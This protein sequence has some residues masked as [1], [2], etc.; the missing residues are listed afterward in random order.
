MA[1]AEVRD[2]DLRALSRELGRKPGVGY[3]L[4]DSVP[5]PCAGHV[6]DRR[7]AGVDWLAAHNHYLRVVEE[8]ARELTPGPLF[9]APQE[10][11]PADE[12]ALIGL[13]REARTSLVGIVL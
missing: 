3:A 9:P 1:L 13:Y 5:V 2:L 7:T 4:P 12:V 8:E 6:P 11:L 10:R